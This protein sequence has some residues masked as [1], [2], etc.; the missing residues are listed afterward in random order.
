MRSPASQILRRAGRRAV[1]GSAAPGLAESTEDG[2]AVTA[3]PTMAP[4]PGVR[5]FAKKF[6]NLVLKTHEGKNVRFYEDLLRD[7]IVLINFM[8]ATCTER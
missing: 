6:P 3:P 8:Y 4:I 5:P 7:K 2:T 1:L